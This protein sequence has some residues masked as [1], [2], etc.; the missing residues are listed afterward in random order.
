MANAVQDARLRELAFLARLEREGAVSVTSEVTHGDAAFK[1]M[2]VQ[3]LRDEC[4]NGLETVPVQSGEP[5]EPHVNFGG[6]SMLQL[7]F[8]ARLWAQVSEVLRDQGTH[9][10]ISHKGRVRR[11][12]LEQALRTGRIGSPS[13]SS[14]RRG[15]VIRRLPWRCWQ[16]SR[17]PR[18]RSSIST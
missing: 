17:A 13:A 1:S 9:V 11:S 15:I 2:L 18:C 8:E 10:R 6:K 4:V 7:K 14:G 3:L 12:E 16:P 5:T